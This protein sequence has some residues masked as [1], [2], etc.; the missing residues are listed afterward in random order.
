MY[1]HQ[2]LS[3]NLEYCS[4]FP[5][6]PRFSNLLPAVH[7]HVALNYRNLCFQ[8]F[9][10]TSLTCSLRQAIYNSPLCFHY[11]YSS[12]TLSSTFSGLHCWILLWKKKSSPFK[13]PGVCLDFQLEI[14]KGWRV[15]LCQRN[16]HFLSTF[17]PLRYTSLSPLLSADHSIQFNKN[18][19]LTLNPPFL[20]TDIPTV[21]SHAI[22][23]SHLHLPS[24]SVKREDSVYLA[25][26]V[27]F[28]CTAVSISCLSKHIGFFGY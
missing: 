8:Y 6:T 12:W 14:S 2:G 20:T 18:I 25:K 21:K 10:T 26:D 28:T 19:T 5:N 16:L 7:S 13:L 11:S 24:P 3:V 17:P 4:S 1:H 15:H 27:P 9:V 23:S 22:H